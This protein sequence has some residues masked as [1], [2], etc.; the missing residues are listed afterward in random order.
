MSN[1]SKIRLDP[2]FVIGYKRSGTTM[3]RL[4]LNAHPDLAVPPESEYFQKI[5]PIMKNRTFEQSELESLAEAISEMDRCDF[6]LNLSAED[7]RMIIDPVL[8]ATGPEVIASLYHYWGDSQDKK[9]ARWGDKKPQNWQFVYRLKDWYPSSQ[10]IH[11]IRDPR[12]VY[13]SVEEYFPEQVIGRGVLPP[14]IITAW[15]WRLANREM[16][17]QGKYLGPDRYLSFKYESLV[18]DPEQYCKKCCK[19]LGIEFK[20][21]M[22][23]FQKSA[24]DPSVQGVKS[25]SGA[26]KQTA[27]EIHSGRIGR[28]KASSL[29]DNILADIEYICKDLFDIYDWS[30]SG[31]KIKSSK[32]MF[33]NIVCHVLD[34]LW[35]GRRFF[36]RLRGSI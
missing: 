25:D 23:K 29:S 34:L 7:I 20:P 4:I 13:A 9:G 21:E 6:K 24:K 17:L 28:F 8:P 30:L 36:K 10:Y 2:V 27:Q 11:V 1:T 26:H 15:Q 33:L 31:D 35:A 16:V 32:A 3:L 12:D 22:L 19:F 5:P 18:N 14:H